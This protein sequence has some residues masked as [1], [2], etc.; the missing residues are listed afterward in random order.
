MKEIGRVECASNG[1]KVAE[2]NP[3]DDD[4]GWSSSGPEIRFE[5]AE[6]ASNASNEVDENLTDASSDMYEP[7]VDSDRQSEVSSDM[8]E[9]PD[10]G[11][12]NVSVINEPTNEETMLPET[13][14]QPETVDMA[15]VHVYEY[16]ESEDDHDYNMVVRC[17][18]AIDRDQECESPVEEHWIKDEDGRE[19]ECNGPPEWVLES[20]EEKLNSEY[21]GDYDEDEDASND[22]DELSEDEY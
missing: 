16:Y 5:K 22:E 12:D 6:T 21:S 14:Q 15:C 17:D 8:D 2:P 19:I 20:E 11:S 4:D 9:E 1:Q 10:R 13:G 18:D 3:Y 7:R